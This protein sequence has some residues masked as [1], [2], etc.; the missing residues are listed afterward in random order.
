MLSSVIT[1]PN[2]L[3]PPI[4]LTSLRQWWF[5]QALIFWTNVD[6]ATSCKTCTF[7]WIPAV[8]YKPT[9]IP[10]VNP[11]L[12]PIWYAK[13]IRSLLIKSNQ[14]IGL[15]CKLSSVRMTLMHRKNRLA[16]ECS[17][18]KFSLKQLFEAPGWGCATSVRWQAVPNNRSRVSESSRG[19][20]SGRFR[21]FQKM[22]ITGSQH[23]SRNIV[24]Q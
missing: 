9:W 2:I 24:V 15:T 12:S 6:P 10:A 20:G 7:T 4:F 18:K 23:T 21:V 22:L 11:F 13:T 3:V 5:V 16:A 1:T 14:T 8:L 17:R 19:L